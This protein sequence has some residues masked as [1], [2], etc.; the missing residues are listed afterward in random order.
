MIR[1]VWSTVTCITM[2]W[3]AVSTAAAAA[4]VVPAVPVRTNTVIATT[5]TAAVNRM[6]LVTQPALLAV[7]APLLPHR[8][9]QQLPPPRLLRQHLLHL[10]HPRLLLPPLVQP[11][12]PPLLIITTKTILLASVRLMSL[13]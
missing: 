1:R 6:L 12:T 10:P 13:S 3:R 7:R 11:I 5:I 8:P 9:P 4:A 2:V